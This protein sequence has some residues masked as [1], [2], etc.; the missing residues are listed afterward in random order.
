MRD[1]R[2]PARH[3]PKWRRS[4]EWARKARDLRA[5]LPQV[6]AGAGVGDVHRRGASSRVQRRPALRP[7]AGSRAGPCPRQERHK[8]LSLSPSTLRHVAERRPAPRARPSQD[9]RA[10]T[11]RFGPAFLDIP[12]LTRGPQAQRLG[13]MLRLVS[14]HPS[15]RAGLGPVTGLPGR[16][17]RQSG[18]GAGSRAGRA[19]RRDQHARP[20]RAAAQRPGALITSRCSP[21][22][23]WRC[24]LDRFRPISTRSRP[25]ARC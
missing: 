2:D 14:F 23:V 5:H 1:G 8:T 22:P 3:A 19:S 4:Q 18:R 11:E 20:T 13:A 25:W 15:R 16:P 6:I 7:V 24:R 17:P 21:A 9:G 12:G 10:R